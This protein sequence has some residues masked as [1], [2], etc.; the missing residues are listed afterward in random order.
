MLRTRL[1]VDEVFRAL[2]S[3]LT[4]EEYRPGRSYQIPAAKVF[5]RLVVRDDKRCALLADMLIHMR[6]D[7][8]ADPFSE[9]AEDLRLA[10]KLVS[11]ALGADGASVLDLELVGCQATLPYG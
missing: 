6:G 1:A 10:D 8:A 2:D 5:R 7:S 4:P 11:D 9:M 3:S